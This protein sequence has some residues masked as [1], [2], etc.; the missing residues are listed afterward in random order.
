M[1]KTEMAYMKS[2]SE[3]VLYQRTIRCSASIP[4]W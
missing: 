4:P 3:D 2:L 1:G